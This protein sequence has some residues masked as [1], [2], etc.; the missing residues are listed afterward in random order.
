M[1]KILI[2]VYPAC[3]AVVLAAPAFAY[4]DPSVTTALLSAIVAA[5]VAVGATVGVLVRKAKK[6]AQQVLNIDENANKIVEDE[7]VVSA[8]PVAAEDKT[9][10]PAEA[11]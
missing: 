11:K 8:A 1:K 2:P 10:E 4:V 3:A 6:K 9:E 5:V 7:I